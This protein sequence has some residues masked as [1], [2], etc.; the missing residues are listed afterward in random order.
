MV[1]YRKLD[2]TKILGPTK[3]VNS[4]RQGC[5]DRI[6]LTQHN[7]SFMATPAVQPSGTRKAKELLTARCLPIREFFTLPS[8]A[9]L[10]IAGR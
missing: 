3:Q 7:G 9:C 6:Q 10:A 4:I 1:H 5:L 2:L 8:R